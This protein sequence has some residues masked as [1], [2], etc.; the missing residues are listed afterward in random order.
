MPNIRIT[1]DI[2]DS[3]LLEA[4]GGV[5]NFLTRKLKRGVIIHGGEVIM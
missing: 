5:D 3:G 4:G 2:K 1:L